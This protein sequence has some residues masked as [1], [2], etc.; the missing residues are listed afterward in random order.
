MNPTPHPSQPIAGSEHLDRAE[1]LLGGA[2]FTPKFWV[3]VD[4]EVQ[5][6]LAML[7]AETRRKLAAVRVQSGRTMGTAFFLCSYRTFSITDSAID[8][9][10]VAI[11]FAPAQ[12]GATVEAGVSGEHFG[13][14]IAEFPIETVTAS[15]QE[16]LAA[17]RIS[18]R[19]LRGTADSIVAALQSASRRLE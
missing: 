19:T 6:E 12:Q 16:I 14:I 1:V 8:P 5:K 17:A 13:D 3:E 2:D 10:V 15:T 9:V 7:E 11:T 18:A 4:D